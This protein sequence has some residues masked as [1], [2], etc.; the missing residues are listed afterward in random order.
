MCSLFLKFLINENIR[1]HL[2][3]RSVKYLNWCV[4]YHVTWLLNFI[5]EVLSLSEL[6]LVFGGEF[7]QQWRLWPPHRSSWSHCL[8][9]PSGGT[10]P[11]VELRH[12][13]GLPQLTQCYSINHHNSIPFKLLSFLSP[14]QRRDWDYRTVWSESIFWRYLGPRDR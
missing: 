14:L 11:G 8:C 3:I 2:M 13:P 9:S 6:F 4:K 12:E 5:F 1:P 10:C 7:R